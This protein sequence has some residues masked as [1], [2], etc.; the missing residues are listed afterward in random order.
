MAAL[1]IDF[2]LF[3]HTCILFQIGSAYK[4]CWVF[5][6]QPDKGRICPCRCLCLKAYVLRQSRDELQVLECTSCSISTQ[7][8]AGTAHVRAESD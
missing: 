2:M 6:G 5:V 1:W 7:T 4:E 8:Q 3:M